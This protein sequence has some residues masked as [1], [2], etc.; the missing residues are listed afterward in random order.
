[1][2]LNYRS[3]KND[4]NPTIGCIVLTNPVFFKKE[5]WIET[6]KDW[7]NSIVQGKSYNTEDAIG[8]EIWNRVQ[9]LLQK[10]LFSSNEGGKSQLILEE[11]NITTV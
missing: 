1:M 3:D 6:P 2:I 7:S 5:D 4:S 10:Y 8:N 11:A 9:I